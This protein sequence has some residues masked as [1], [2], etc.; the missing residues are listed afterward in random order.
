[1]IFALAAFLGLSDAWHELFVP[2]GTPVLG[3]RFDTRA[4][5]AAELPN[6]AQARTVQTSG[7]AP[8]VL[9]SVAVICA[10]VGVSGGVLDPRKALPRKTCAAW[11]PAAHARRQPR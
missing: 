9:V 1:M 2:I 3:S 11:Q 7:A 4:V 5:F 8:V 10:A 6:V